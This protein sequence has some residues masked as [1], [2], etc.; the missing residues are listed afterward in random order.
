M[1]LSMP[2]A[3]RTFT[4][5][6][7]A[8][9]TVSLRL[10][11]FTL[12]ISA[13]AAPLSERGRGLNLIRQDKEVDEASSKAEVA[14]N[15]DG[16][17]R[18]AAMDDAGHRGRRAG[19]DEGAIDRLAALDVEAAVADGGDVV[20]I[21][22]SEADTGVKAFGALRRDQGLQRHDDRHV[23]HRQAWVVQR[24][25]RRPAA[26]IG[27]DGDRLEAPFGGLIDLNRCRRRQ[28]RL[29]DE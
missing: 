18:R 10:S 25:A 20:G 7:G 22:E 3:S 12:G 23:A 13:I 4:I 15:A 16:V 17:Q 11:R 5:W 28:F 6:S 29:A 9:I 19:K 27:D 1:S 24:A 8:A 2:K 14:V 26:E 21:P